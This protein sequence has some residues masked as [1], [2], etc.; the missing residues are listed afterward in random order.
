MKKMASY[1][2]QTVHRVTT[3]LLAKIHH[4][5]PGPAWSPRMKII[6]KKMA[7]TYNIQSVVNCRQFVLS[8]M[9]TLAVQNL[10]ELI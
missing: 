4:D 9:K 1:R 5:F 2:V 3:L 8:Q 6:K 7:F 10:D